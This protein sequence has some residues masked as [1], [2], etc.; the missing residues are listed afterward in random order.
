MDKN[1]QAGK[2]LKNN[3]DDCHYYYYYYYYYYKRLLSENFTNG[4][5][6]FLLLKY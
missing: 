2:R 1:L 3:K 5:F 6:S 4:T